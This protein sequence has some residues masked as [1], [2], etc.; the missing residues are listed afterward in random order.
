VNIDKQTTARMFAIVLLPASLVACGQQ[1]ARTAAAR[2]EFH[3]RFNAG[4][5]HEIYAASAIGDRRY[6]GD[7]ESF[8]LRAG[9]ERRDLGKFEK[10]LADGPVQETET[11]YGGYDYVV[12]VFNTRYSTYPAV[13][14][15][16]WKIKG[17]QVR[18]D[19]YTLAPNAEIRCER[20][21]DCHTVQ[22]GP[23]AATPPLSIAGPDRRR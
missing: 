12:Q 14:N 15:L 7:E 8:L 9:Q 5:F 10:D 6:G 21:S 2:V 20:K 3:E 11:S 18:L 13:E 4:Q 19:N 17:D 22:L 23:V 16:I 1:R